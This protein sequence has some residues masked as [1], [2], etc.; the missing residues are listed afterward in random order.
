MNSF[1]ITHEMLTDLDK[2]KEY[3]MSDKFDG[4]SGYNNIA[5]NLGN[6]YHLMSDSV[7]TYVEYDLSL[8]DNAALISVKNYHPSCLEH[9]LE[10]QRE[11]PLVDAHFGQLV[12]VIVVSY[13]N[14][15]KSPHDI[16]HSYRLLHDIGDDIRNYYHEEPEIY[17][18]RLEEITSAIKSKSISSLKFEGDPIIKKLF[19]KLTEKAVSKY[20]RPFARAITNNLC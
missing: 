14:R 12:S 17:M 15:R 16:R 3:I 8:A 11:Y 2:M 10:L 18:G 13:V 5:C 4:I 7:Q 20:Y 19:R 6:Y 1:P 9:Q